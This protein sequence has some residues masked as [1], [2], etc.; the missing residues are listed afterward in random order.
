M[1]PEQAELSGNDID[2]RSDIYSLG[3][4]LYELLTGFTPFDAEKLSRAGYGEVQRIIR[5]EEPPTPSTRL[6]ALTKRDLTAV[7]RQRQI[8]PRSLCRLLRGD[9]DW[10]VMKALEK[11]RARRYETA[12]ALALDIERHL[13]Q[14]PVEAGPPGR[15]YRLEKFVQ[16]NRIGVLV[17]VVV[18]AALL[19]GLGAATYGLIRARDEAAIAEEAQRATETSAA[20]ARDEATRARTEAT[21]AR[22]VIQLLKEMLS[23]ADPHLTRGRKYTVRQLL[24]DFTGEGFWEELA[25]QPEIELTLRQTVGNAYL[26][27]GEHAEAGAHLT[28][29]LELARRHR[30]E[31][32]TET[33]TC[34]YLQGCLLHNQ[35]KYHEARALFEKVVARRRKELGKDHPDTLAAARFLSDV[36]RHLGEYAAAETMAVEVLDAYRR[37]LGDKHGKTVV[38]MTNLGLLYRDQGRFAEAE[39]LFEEAAATARTAFGEEHPRTLPTL[40]NLAI[41]YSDL[42]RYAQAEQLHDRVLEADRRIFGDD[43]PETLRSMMNQ[44]VVYK[45]QGRYAEAE[46]LARQAFEAN[47]RIYGEEHSST[48]PFMVTLAA[49]YRAQG[50]YEEAEPL[51][52]EAL[53]IQRL[54]LGEKHHRTLE[55]TGGLAL[56]YIE[57][58]RYEEAQPLLDKALKTALGAL[59]ERHPATLDLMRNLGWLYTKRRRYAEAEPLL[60]KAL[61]GQ[62]RILGDEHIDTASAMFGLATVKMRQGQHVEAEALFKRVI[63]ISRPLFGDEHV[64]ILATT[65]NLANLYTLQGRHGDA[66]KLRKRA[67]DIARRTLGDRHPTTLKCADN[68]IKTYVAMRRFQDGL[69]ML[70]LLE[71]MKAGAAWEPAAVEVLVPRGSE[72]KFLESGAADSTAWRGDECDDREW[73][74]GPAPLGYGKAIY[75]TR[76]ALSP[77]GENPI[78]FRRA[79]DVRRPERFETL[80]IR[81]R[82]AAS[83]TVYINDIEMVREDPAAGAAQDEPGLY[84]RGDV[85]N[86]RYS[87][88]LAPADALRPGQNAIAVEVY[89]SRGESPKL[90]FDLVLEGKLRDAQPAPGDPDRSE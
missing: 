40:T 2:T 44:A 22:T 87:V 49:V 50:R 26:G 30:G 55:T 69:A 54:T 34:L 70:D 71:D 51:A 33:T 17:T 46:T 61:E 66:E 67:F 8:E 73:K 41:I 16:R 35:G 6:S 60:K 24:D 79:F 37:L 27:L 89:P 85:R 43:H 59:G 56:L 19:A 90:L 11:D 74:S 57:Q 38:A 58:S 1:S 64:T 84:R 53:Q 29:A 39:K 4:L 15:M 83:A 72:W 88:F 31:E 81:L 13:R 80:K 78:H 42:G 9:L 86:P 23:S 47:R 32:D 14:E 48:A 25:K 28:R 63:E 7:A 75:A 21:R 52:R 18:L 65:N 10:I 45:S 76:L 62:R 68:L 3:V 77:D 82:R 36:R 5:D 20:A 12:A